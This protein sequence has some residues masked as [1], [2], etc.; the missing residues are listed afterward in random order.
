MFA[1][2]GAASAAF[3]TQGFGATSFDI[4]HDPSCDF[5]VQTGFQ[6][7]MPLLI[8]MRDGGLIMVGPLCLL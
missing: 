2:C 8:K 3:A 1:G 7:A 6:K 4:A 5:T